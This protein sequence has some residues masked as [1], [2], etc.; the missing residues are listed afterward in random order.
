[1]YFLGNI[2]LSSDG[3]VKLTDFGASKFLREN[4][5]QFAF[6]YVNKENKF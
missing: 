1:M 6:T 5:S 2:V 4:V 3:K